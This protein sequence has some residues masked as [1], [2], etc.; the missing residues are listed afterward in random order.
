MKGLCMTSY[1]NILHDCIKNNNKE[2]SY[3]LTRVELTRIYLLTRNARMLTLRA[4][5]RK[6]ACLSFRYAAIRTVRSNLTKRKQKVT[7]D[8]I[9]NS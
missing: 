1:M 9:Y 5:Y 2:N 3:L 6:T 7:T 4:P 8:D